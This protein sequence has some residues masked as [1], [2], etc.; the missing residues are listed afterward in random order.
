MMMM[1]MITLYIQT[2]DPTALCMCKHIHQCI[3]HTYTQYVY[4]KFVP[5]VDYEPRAFFKFSIKHIRQK[6]FFD[7]FN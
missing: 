7:F 3:M 6:K 4:T 2:G 5:K 1:M